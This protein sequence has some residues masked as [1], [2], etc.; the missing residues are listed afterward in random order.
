[1]RGTGESFAINTGGRL[2]GTSFAWLTA[3][4]AIT[5]DPAYAPTKVALVAAGVGFSVLLIGC[6]LSFW[7]PE[8]GKDE[9]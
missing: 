4:L 9:Q 6:L 2:V 1:L 3:T 5:T 7:L 8:P